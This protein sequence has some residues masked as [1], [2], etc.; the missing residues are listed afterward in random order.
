[1]SSPTCGD[2]LVGV[3]DHEAEAWKPD[4][5]GPRRA[6]EVGL[7]DRLLDLKVILS[8]PGK[9]PDNRQPDHRIENQRCSND[10]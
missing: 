1:M 7:L 5:V 10:R 2:G 4:G 6:R 3:N 8:V 9:Y